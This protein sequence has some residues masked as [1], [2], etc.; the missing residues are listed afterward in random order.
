MESGK[1][2]IAVFIT[3]IFLTGCIAPA[4]PIAI[5]WDHS[6]GAIG[7][8]VYVADN[9]QFS[10]P[11]ITD[12]GYKNT[13]PLVELTIFEGKKNWVVVTAYNQ[14][15]ESEYSNAVEFTHFV[16]TKSP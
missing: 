13:V 12:V 5:S 6:D 10:S 7:Y 3:L 9:E 15:N 16:S 8:K 11:Q 4:N 14:V 2:I 1:K